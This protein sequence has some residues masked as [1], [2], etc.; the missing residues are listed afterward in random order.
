MQEGG[1]EVGPPNTSSAKLDRLLLMMQDTHARLG[2]LEQR[3]DRHT[4]THNEEHESQCGEKNTKIDHTHQTN[5]EEHTFS[6]SSKDKTVCIVIF[7][8][9]EKVKPPQYD[10]SEAG[11]ATEA[12][13]IRKEKY[14]EIQ[15]YTE[16]MKAVWED[17]QLI[18]EVVC[19]W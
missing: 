6:Q 5:S 9:M 16:N 11:D 7:D 1:G 8:N 3:E 10:G 14:F 2:H 19:W 12:W 17:Y 13:L 4:R 15:D 18:G